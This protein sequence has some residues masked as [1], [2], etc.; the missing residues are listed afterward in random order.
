MP[1]LLL[2]PSSSLNQFFMFFTFLCQDSDYQQLSFSTHPNFKTYVQKPVVRR[3]PDDS[4][5]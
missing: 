5:G 2:D 1:D 4:D 3:P